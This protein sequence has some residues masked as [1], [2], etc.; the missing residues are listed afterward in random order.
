MDFVGNRTIWSRSGHPVKKFHTSPARLCVRAFQSCHGWCQPLWVIRIYINFPLSSGGTRVKNHMARW[1][2]SLLS[3]CWKCP[4][5]GQQ[6]RPGRQGT[7]WQH[8]TLHWCQLTID[9]WPQWSYSPAPLYKQPLLFNSLLSTRPISSLF[10][11]L[12]C[13]CNA[14]FFIEILII[15][16]NTLDEYVKVESCVWH[17]ICIY[18]KISQCQSLIAKVAMLGTNSVWR[19]CCQQKVSHQNNSSS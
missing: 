1:N 17:R 5:T 11:F 13:I 10:F 6:M 9:L 3:L 18:T 14:N 4:S 16:G 12:N 8:R 2:M 19:H 7:G 15:S